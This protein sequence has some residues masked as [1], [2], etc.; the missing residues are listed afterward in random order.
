MLDKKQ[1]KSTEFADI[2]SKLMDTVLRLTYDAPIKDIQ[3]QNLVKEGLLT[4]AKIDD[5]KFITQNNRP[6]E[7]AK[8]NAD[9]SLIEK[10]KEL[11]DAQ[12]RDLNFRIDNFLPKEME[13][14]TQEVETL[15]AQVCKINTECDLTRAK[16]DDQ[17]FVTEQI[18]PLERI[19]VEYEAEESKYRVQLMVAQVDLTEAQACKTRKECDLVDAQITRMEYENRFILPADKKL[20]EAQADK[21]YADARVAEKQIEI[22]DKDLQIKEEQLQ[23]A[24]QELEL[25]KKDLELKDAQIRFTDRQIEGFD[26]NIR[27]KMLEIQM[28]S[29]SM[30]FSSGLLEEKPKIIC[31]DAV[32][33]L[34]K[35]MSDH[36]DVPYNPSTCP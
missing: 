22:A 15:K 26:D 8:I 1:I 9:I 5:Q 19:K 25:K 31:N 13:K 10:Q 11:T 34:Y 2:Y 32:T 33:D 7:V 12:I 28:N 14:I 20:K 27:Q 16:T 30:M 29:W 21:M 6:A 23:I 36:A 17:R 24:K 4:D 18:R 3:V 35:Y